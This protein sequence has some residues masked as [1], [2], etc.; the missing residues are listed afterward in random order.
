MLTAP[1]AYLRRSFVDAES[2]GDISEAAQLAT[3][4]K[5][6][7]ADGHNGNLVVYSDWGVSAD[8]AKSAK[9]TEYARLLAD[10]EAGSI[11]AVYAFDVDRLYRDPR[12]LIRLQDAA[13]KHS[14]RI[15]TTG[16][17]LAIGDGDD[18]SAEAFAFIGAIFGRMELQKAKKRSR[19][20]RDARRE[21]DGHLVNQPPYGFM[22]IREDGRIVQVP[23]PDQP[24][25]PLIAAYKEAGS[26][27]GACRLLR[28]DKV[29]APRGGERWSTSALTRILERAQAA[30]ADVTLPVKTPAGRRTPAR[31]MLAQLLRCPFCGRMLTPNVKRGQLYCANGSRDRVTHPRYAVREVDV[32]PWVQA[33]A[34]RFDPGDYIEAEGAEKERRAIIDR[35][36]AALELYLSKDPMMTR[37]RYQAEQERAARDLEAL[38]TRGAL[39]ALPESVD[40]DADPAKVNAFLRSIFLA[41]ELDSQLLPVRA[42]W[43]V[44]EYRAG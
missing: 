29:P 23:N 31:A 17:P 7:A 38:E 21:R 27:L 6:A 3:V 30:G 41:I 39:A 19:A 16:G 14:V 34:D 1:A 13:T 37:E 2:P 26:I 43:R 11:Q 22:N 20:A 10:M 40:W 42:E 35:R 8:I 28:R 9:R 25:E 5:L 24:I 36:E 12:D 32:L 4:R 44:P 18:P 15:V 33:E